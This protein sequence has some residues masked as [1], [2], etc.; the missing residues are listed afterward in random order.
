MPHRGERLRK[1]LDANRIKYAQLAR[2][3]GIHKNTMQNWLD[4]VNLQDEHIVKI[5]SRYPSI[6]DAF[7]EINWP[8]FETFVDKVEDGSAEYGVL[9]DECQKRISK[10]KDKYL[11]LSDRYSSL[12]EKH[13][14]LLETSMKS[15]D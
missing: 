15:G 6:K 3:I 13:T 8:A 10:W 12:L 1:Y 4:H 7:P 5:S 9:S 11:E 2:E 14:L